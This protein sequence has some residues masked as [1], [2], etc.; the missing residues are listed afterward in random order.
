MGNLLAD[1]SS[2]GFGPIVA[3]TDKFAGF[4]T[5]GL[6]TGWHITIYTSQTNE[7]LDFVPVIEPS[8]DQ[9]GRTSGPP[10]TLRITENGITNFSWL[11]A[12]GNI[13]AFLDG[14]RNAVAVNMDI[15]FAA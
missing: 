8:L 2:I 9:F 15:L 5:T 12:R 1:Q 11:P 13:R 4:N 6:V 14:G 7:V 3:V 10:R